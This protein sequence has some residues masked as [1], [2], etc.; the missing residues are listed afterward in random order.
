MSL[1][2]WDVSFCLF[3]LCSVRSTSKICWK[4]FALRDDFVLH[5]FQIQ[6]D[7]ESRTIAH[8][9]FLFGDRKESKT[10]MIIHT[11]KQGHNYGLNWRHIWTR[12]Y[13]FARE[14]S[15]LARKSYWNQ[16]TCHSWKQA[17]MKI[18]VVLS[19]HLEASRGLPGC[20]FR[21]VF[22]QVQEEASPRRNAVA[23]CRVIYKAPM[24]TVMPKAL[25]APKLRQLTG[26]EA[27]RDW[28]LLHIF[29][30]TGSCSIIL[31]ALRGVN[32]Q[33]RKNARAFDLKI[34]ST[35]FPLAGRSVYKNLKYL[36]QMPPTVCNITPWVVQKL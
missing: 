5:V 6:R 36:P 11:K 21:A 29:C 22:E 2:V 8:C 15:A 35:P 3:V 1:Q 12:G 31:L 34:P 4:Y 33:T 10:A 16:Q 19:V 7:H 26:A 13:H 9:S 14:I 30:I 24:L 32:S 25:R 17:C 23:A 27:T 18:S 28:F 20:S